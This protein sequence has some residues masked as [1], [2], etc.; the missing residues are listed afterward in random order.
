MLSQTL[1]RSAESYALEQRREIGA[2]VSAAVRLWSRVG[3][4]FDASYSV[5]EAPLLAVARTAQ[6]RVADGAVRYIPEVLADTGQ[7]SPPPVA[8]VRTTALVGAAGDGRDVG[9]LL[10]GAVTRAKAAVGAGAPVVEALSSGGAFLSKALATVLS[11][12]GRAGERL[13]MSVR[14]G[15]GAYVRMLVPPSC[16]RCV[17]LAGVRY[18]ASAAFQRHPQCDC[19]HIPASESVAGELTV[20]PQGY[21]ESLTREQQDKAFGRAG[22]EAI[23]SGADMNQVV[24]ARRGV[25]RAQVAGRDVLVTS[26]GTTRRGFAYTRMNRMIANETG[27]AAR[28]G[29]LATRL[30]REGAQARRVVRNVTRNARLMPETIQQLA[31]DRD[32]YLRLLRTY[33][34]IL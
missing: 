30:T 13:G 16:S 27:D 24:N 19:R 9:S 33:G 6:V 1:P 12:T 5:I 31:T 25:R 15:V 11:D 8:M 21:F 7:V 18:K 20:D 10:Y 3:E 34:F 26:E 17:I 32:D 22:A 28:V 4:D 14:P 2:A 23:R 29:E